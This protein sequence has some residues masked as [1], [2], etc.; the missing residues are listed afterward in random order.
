MDGNF[1]SKI[2]MSCHRCEW[3]QIN[4]NW[5]P[6]LRNFEAVVTLLSGVASIATRVHYD[7]ECDLDKQGDLIPR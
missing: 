4:P 2:N 7:N 1:N 5:R 6:C 3:L